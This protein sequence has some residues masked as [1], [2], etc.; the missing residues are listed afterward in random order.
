MSTGEWKYVFTLRDT[1]SGVRYAK[2]RVNDINGII[3]LPDDWKSGFYGFYS[4][5]NPNTTGVPFETNIITLSDW[6]EKLESNGAVF[7]PAGGERWDTQVH[8]AG[9]YGLYWASSN[10][11]G[12]FVNEISFSDSYFNPDYFGYLFY[13]R[14]VRLVR[15]H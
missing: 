2:A 12:G 13:G 1:P 5:Q 14:S 15:N 9:A 8:N 10:R 7:L 3:V 6:T 11:G 4:L